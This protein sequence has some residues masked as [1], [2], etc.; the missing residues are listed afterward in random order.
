[1]LYLLCPHAPP[2][3]SSRSVSHSTYAYVLK[4]VRRRC[5]P[6]LSSNLERA[7]ASSHTGN[8]ALSSMPVSCKE[9]GLTPTFCAGVAGV[10]DMSQVLPLAQIS[11]LAKGVCRL[12]T[13]AVCEL[14]HPPSVQ[15]SAV[16]PG[17]HCTGRRQMWAPCP[18]AACYRPGVSASLPSHQ[19]CVP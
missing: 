16:R 9:A 10:A 19:A 5:K 2:G 13:Q 18:A 4:A 6:A 15:I 1:M 7:F 17:C 3:L 14:L 11:C 12:G 8:I